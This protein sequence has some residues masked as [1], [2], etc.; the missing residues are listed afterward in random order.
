MTKTKSIFGQGI[1][2]IE[3]RTATGR[4]MQLLLARFDLTNQLKST[5]QIKNCNKH[6]GNETSGCRSLI[7]KLNDEQHKLSR[8]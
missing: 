2:L 4:R 8:K 5:L 6:Q 1:N 7:L 3:T